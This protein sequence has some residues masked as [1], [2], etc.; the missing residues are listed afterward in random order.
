M[1]HFVLHRIRDK[2]KGG[3]SGRP[4]YLPAFDAVTP[5]A[6][7]TISPSASKSL[8]RGEVRRHARPM[9]RAGSGAAK[10]NSFTRASRPSTSTATSRQQRDAVAVRHHLHHG[11]KR[12]GAKSGRRIAARCRAEGQRLVA[13]AVA[14][15]QQNQPA[16][17]D[18][19]DVDARARRQRIRRRH[20]QQERVVEQRQRLDVGALDR[21]RQH[22]GVE[23]AARQFVEQQLG[24]RLAHFQPQLR[25]FACS[26]GSTRGS[27]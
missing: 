5:S 17:I 7:L 26:R 1:H 4:F 27:M 20:R 15:L 25:I 9:V 3:P 10:R 21:Q 14:L 22:R 16:L 8:R 2:K 13:Q 23:F 18:I 12:G 19:L 6:S 24:L 11:G